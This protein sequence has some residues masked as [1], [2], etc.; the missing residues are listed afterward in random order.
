MK[1]WWKNLLEN[2]QLKTINFLWFLYDLKRLKKLFEMLEKQ[3]EMRWE[4]IYIYKGT[5]VTEKI[6][7]C[8]FKLTPLKWV[9]DDCPKITWE[10]VE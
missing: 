2:T 10:I 1:C 9:T 8:V 5:L 7:V 4:T 6:F 3:F